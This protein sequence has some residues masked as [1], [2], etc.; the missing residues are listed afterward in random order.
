MN[1]YR[2]GFA[3][4][5][6]EFIKYRKASGMISDGYM[7]NL[8]LFDQFCAIN[9][10]PGTPL[11]QDMVDIWC[12]KR[13]T[14]LNRSCNTRVRPI[15][16]FIKFLRKHDSTDVALPP[17]LKAE[18][19][20]YIPHTFTHEELKNFFAECD[21]LPNKYK[22]Q[23]VRK[24]VCPVLFRLLYSSGIRTTEARLLRR[25]HV[26]L[27]RGILSIEKSKGYDQHYVALHKSMTELLR[28]Y[29]SAMDT[30]QPQRTYFFE[31]PLG[32]CYSREWLTN[33][34]REIWERANGPGS[35]AIPYALRHNYA[36]EN[37]NRWKEDG[38]EF[39][40][41]L[42]Y[43]SKSMGHREIASTLHYYSITP[44]LADTIQ[45][46]T[47]KGFNSIVPEASYEE[48]E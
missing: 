27:E 47:E 39:S 26:D 2:S 16:A 18:P 12:A 31:S 44:R 22:S 34:F 6:Q 10:P 19:W 9:Y 4:L 32:R 17:V 20:T 46:K 24:L 36:V 8:G 3:D 48:S 21:A 41:R 35:D 29:D 42:N 30:I 13:D 43:L 1:T 11:I 45:S 25:E 37:I 38:F 28:K 5:I 33:I 7:Y 14:E 15:R 40:D 23:Q